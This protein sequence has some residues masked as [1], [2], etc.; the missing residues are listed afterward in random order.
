[1][2]GPALAARAASRERG[3]RR[4]RRGSGAAPAPPPYKPPSDEPLDFRGPGRDEPEPDVAEVVIGWFG[5]GDPAHPDFGDYWRGATL[6]LEQEN[7]AGG[8]RGKPLPARGRVVGE[9]VDGR[10]R[11]RDARSST[12]A[13]PG[14]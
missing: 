2:L 7:A 14:P 9:P 8:Y 13:A 11:R 1:M 12:T 5:P 6:A 4:A 3:S 10:H